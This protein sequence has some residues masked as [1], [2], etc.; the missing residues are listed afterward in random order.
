MEG[1]EEIKKPED[2]KAT[3]EVKA[4]EEKPEEKKMI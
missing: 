2:N 1:K 4:S 3:E